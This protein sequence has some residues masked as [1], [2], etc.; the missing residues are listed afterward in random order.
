MSRL[1]LAVLLAAACQEVEGPAGSPDALVGQS[2]LPGALLLDAPSMYAGEVVKLAVSGATPGERVYF[3]LSRAG[4]AQKTVCPAVLSDCLNLKGPITL[5]GSTI[6]SGTGEA[7]IT[8]PVPASAL[9]ASIFLQSASFSG[10]SSVAHRFV[11]PP[12]S[13]CG[14]GIA[15]PRC[16]PT[17]E[18][19]G[20]WD[21][22]G[23]QTCQDVYDVTLTAGT[24]LTLDVSGVTGQSVVRLAVFPPGTGLNGTNL[25]TGGN[26]DQECEGQ[27]QDVSATVLA[28]TTGTYRVAVGRDWGS[29]AGAVGAYDLVMSADPGLD[30]VGRTADDM[31]SQAAG[32]QCG[33]ITSVSSD[34]DCAAGQSCQDVYDF[35]VTE[36]E[37]VTFTVSGIT[38]QSVDRLALYA[39]GEALDSRNLLTGTTA[40][41]LCGGQ[42]V[43]DTTHTWIPHTTGTFR[44]AVGRDWGA[45]AGAVGN[46]RL[47][48]TSLDGPISLT[49]T[50]D[51]TS[52]LQ[53]NKQCGFTWT[54][55]GSWVCNAGVSCQ[56]VYEVPAVAGGSLTVTHA[57][58]TGQSVSRLAVFAPDVPLSGTN[59]LTSNT[60]DLECSGQNTPQ[61]GGPVNTVDGSYAVGVGRDWGSSAGA[62]GDYTVSFAYTGGYPYITMISQGT[63]SEASGSSCP[64]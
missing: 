15:P 28:P 5:L 9:Y 53:L 50:S 49:Q 58:L 55:S 45:S 32:S 43:G 21:C 34:W 17:H 37:E 35:F 13:D 19:S 44:V 60:T 33:Y 59:L 2:P 26:L 56:D 40:D 20:T 10:T 64:P 42:N 31:V 14:M 48:V 61:V 51:D 6:A 18:V 62:V 1:M 25:L 16:E 22:G 24:E 29:S 41:R 63:A 54:E 11:E 7:S 12:N 36:G 4:V 23:G 30:F 38:G 52:S 47:D 27:N 46:Y 39:P 3:G 8:V 57:G